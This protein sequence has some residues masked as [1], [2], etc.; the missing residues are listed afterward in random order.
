MRLCCISTAYLRPVEDAELVHVVPDVQVLGGALVLVE[1]ELVGPPLSGGGIQVVWV[2]RG[3]GPTPAA[4]QLA[5]CQQAVVC[6]RALVRQARSWYSC[7]HKA[8]QRDNKT[9]SRV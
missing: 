8:G 5:V 2:G 3:P 4:A 9:A 7:S 1:H 6:Q